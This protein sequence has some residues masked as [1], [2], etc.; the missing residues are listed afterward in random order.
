[1]SDRWATMKCYSKMRGHLLTHIFC[2]PL[3]L[4]AEEA[5]SVCE[6]LRQMQRD[7]QRNRE[8]AQAARRAG[9]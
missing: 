5:E 9:R 2:L 1:M 7:L 8:E 3:D 6:A 4:T